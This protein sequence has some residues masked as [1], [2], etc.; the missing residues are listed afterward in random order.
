MGLAARDGVMET[1][2]RFKGLILGVI[3]IVGS[4]Y[5][6]DHGGAPIGFESRPMVDWDVVASNFQVLSARVHAEW[7]RLM[8]G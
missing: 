4:V 6:S 2:M 8:A 7:I 1:C 3:L 5:V